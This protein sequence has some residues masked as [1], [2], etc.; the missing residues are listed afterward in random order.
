MAT[1]TSWGLDRVITS[2]LADAARTLEDVVARGHYGTSF[3][4][5]EATL[6][7][8]HLCAD[9]YQ[10]AASLPDTPIAPL[11]PELAITIQRGLRGTPSYRRSREYLSQYWV[12]TL[13]TLAH[14]GPQVIPTSNDQQ[15]PDFLLDLG[16]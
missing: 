14:I 4:Q 11:A 15:R 9:F 1:L 6:E 8:L 16:G 12:A 7:A 3:A 13:F 10:I 5:L 2:R